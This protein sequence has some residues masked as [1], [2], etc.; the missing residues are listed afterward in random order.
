MASS[1][2]LLDHSSFFCALGLTETF[3]WCR[4][5]R[6]CS[7]AA[8]EQGGVFDATTSAAK[9]ALS[10]AHASGLGIA[11][12]ALGFLVMALVTSLGGPTGPGLNPARDFGPRLV[13]AF[14]PKSILGEHKG[15]SKWWYALG[16]SCSPNPCCYLGYFV[17]QSHLSSLIYLKNELD[18][19]IEFVFFIVL[20]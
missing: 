18:F 14:L 5:C 10:Q 13:H 8:A 3:L 20:G 1:T 4:G 12:L 7:K 15:D 6:S 11:H 17:V 9:L 19:P 16:T 2:S